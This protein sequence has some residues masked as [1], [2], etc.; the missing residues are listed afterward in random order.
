[1]RYERTRTAALLL[2]AGLGGLLDGILLQQIAQ[3]HQTVSARVSPL[4]VDAMQLNLL[5]DGLFN[6]LLGAIAL[7]G[8]L[9]LWSGARGRIGPVLG[10]TVTYPYS[11]YF[12]SPR[13]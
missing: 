2:G 13:R 12:S 6:L 10:S 3:W 9:A 7:A 8:T 11:G 1:M 4:T 5:A